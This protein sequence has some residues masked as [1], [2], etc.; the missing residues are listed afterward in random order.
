MAAYVIADMEITDPAIFQEY[1]QH[2]RPTLV[3]YGAKVLVS[4]KLTESVEGNWQPK[5]L[6][7]A[8][9]DTME[10][11]KRWYESPEYREP[12]ALRERSA[13]SN[14]VFVPGLESPLCGTVLWRQPW[15]TDSTYVSMPI[16]TGTH[17]SR[18]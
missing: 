9:F 3:Q 5:L 2:A 18:R 1:L 17:I 12:M 6:V 14:V 8:E 13:K 11:A 7:I 15:Y 16:K 4:T 10:Q